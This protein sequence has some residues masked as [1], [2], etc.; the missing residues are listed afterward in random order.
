[1]EHGNY[2]HRDPENDLISMDELDP[3]P[4][5]E[6]PVV[7]SLDSLPSSHSSDVDIKRSNDTLNRSSTLGL[8]G[9]GTVYYLSRI[10]KY[11]SY[12]FA[13]FLSMHITNNAIIPLFTRSV[14]ASEPYLLLTRPFYQSPLAEPLIVALPLMAHISSGIALRVY[15]RIYLSRRY[16]ADSSL[17]RRGL[18]WPKLS[19][20]SLLGYFLLP[21]AAGHV[22]VNRILPLWI[23]GGNSGIGLSYVS[24]GFAK[25]PVTSFVGYTLLIGLASWHVVWGMAKCVVLAGVWLA[26]GLGVV[27]RGGL[28]TGWVGRGYDEL[29]K[30]I[31]LIGRWL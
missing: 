27:G 31:P 7:L 28:V 9:H 1:M 15:R 25:D 3:S 11:S 23:E 4:V 21:F 19:G 6:D 20:T 8:S 14:V 13:V 16:G 12:T 2:G 30:R 29:Y 22:F 10:Q 24:H 26:G 18:A 5:D 17:E